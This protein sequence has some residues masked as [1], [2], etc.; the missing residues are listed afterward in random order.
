M[1]DKFGCLFKAGRR[2][3]AEL[4]P[5][6]Q[7]RA[8]NEAPKEGPGGHASRIGVRG[9]IQYHPKAIGTSRDC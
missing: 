8:S 4:S 1:S 7:T 2:G 6:L 5:Y 9:A 3:P